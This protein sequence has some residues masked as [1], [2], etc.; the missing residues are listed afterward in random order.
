[1]SEMSG[2]AL[3]A[4]SVEK[5][6]HGDQVQPDDRLAIAACH[7][8]LAAKELPGAREAR[9][10]LVTL[11]A[12]VVR[13][14]VDRYGGT[15]DG[16]Q[17]PSDLLHRAVYQL[18]LAAEQLPHA[19]GAQQM[20]QALHS[21]PPSPPSNTSEP[22]PPAPPSAAHSPSAAEAYDAGA[23]GLA[24]PGRLQPVIPSRLAAG[25]GCSSSSLAVVSPRLAAFPSDT[26]LQR[27]PS[28][29]AVS[30]EQLS[31]SQRARVQQ[32]LF[33]LQ[34]KQQASRGV[35]TA[36]LEACAPQKEALHQQVLQQQQQQQQHRLQHRA[37][38]PPQPPYAA[39]PAWQ[40]LPS[41]PSFAS[42]PSSGCYY[43]TAMPPTRP[44]NNIPP[45]AE[46]YDTEYL[47]R[48]QRQQPYPCESPP[49]AARSRTAAHDERELAE[50]V[51]EAQKERLRKI[52]LHQQQQQQQQ[53]HY[54]S[55]DP[56]MQRSI[57]RARAACTLEQVERD[58][59]TLDVLIAQHARLAA[60]PVS[61]VN[62][63]VLADL[64]RQI[65][66]VK[67]RLLDAAHAYAVEGGDLTG[68][69]AAVRACTP[70]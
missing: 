58:K 36:G 35:R 43:P 33:E 12:D 61:A 70:L 14:A 29:S 46:V 6:V 38:P 55:R 47:S 22:P 3:A 30:P 18:L 44:V 59:A 63:A 51:L 67:R 26:T 57:S 66:V 40:G 39:Q 23:S 11:P 50:A 16:S 49:Y 21:Q 56:S 48:G 31:P 52:R 42:R 60:L 4:S 62:D 32:Q 54:H 65:E 25:A 7:L 13:A 64:M 27:R 34:K 28:P 45:D 8:A 68:A 53:C 1:M 17:L 10:L 24:P 15:V 19:E 2:D 9:Q 20:L 69:A 37:T 41:M 5:A